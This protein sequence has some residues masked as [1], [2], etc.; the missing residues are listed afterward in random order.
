MFKIGERK[1]LLT[2]NWIISVLFA[3]ILIFLWILCYCNKIGN[4]LVVVLVVIFVVVVVVV[5]FV[6]TNKSHNE[7]VPDDNIITKYLQ[8]PWLMEPGGSMQLSKG[9]S[10]NHY[11]EPNQPNSSY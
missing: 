6:A 8:T 3:L 7:D 1:K 11:P 4:V 5:H 9:P 10:N 2:L